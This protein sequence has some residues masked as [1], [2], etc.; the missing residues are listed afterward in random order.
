MLV[1]AMISA[2]GKALVGPPPSG[3]PTNV[4][5]FNAGDEGSPRTGVQWTNADVTAQTQVGFST[6]PVVDP[7]GVFISV[8]PGVTSV[9]TGDS[10]AGRFWF[11]RHAK[12][13]QF[14]VWV[15]G[16]QGFG[17]Q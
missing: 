4:S 16:G 12:N 9:D 5:T 11:A 14:T 3:P 17:D 7:A 1:P 10:T 6:S 13:G 15:L 2:A 8:N